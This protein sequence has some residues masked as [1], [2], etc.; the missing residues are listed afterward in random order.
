MILSI[1]QLFSDS[2]AITADAL[3]TNVIDTGAAGTPYLGNSPLNKDIGKGTPIPVLIQVDEAFNNLTSLEI[4][5]EVSASA[6]MSS[7]TVLASETVA[8][9]DLV[10]G[11]TTHLQCLPNGANLRYLAVRYN[12]TG[13]AP[14]TGTVTAG[15][16]M[17]NQTN[18][19]GA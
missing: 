18:F 17:G 2:Q 7:S 3:S 1:N 10:V 13:T 14:T 4:A 15:I 5:V 16:T 6:D 12:V 8:A 9:A 11:K 19:T